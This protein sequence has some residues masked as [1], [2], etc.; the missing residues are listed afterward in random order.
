MKK[1]REAVASRNV[2]ALRSP[3]MP[4]SNNILGVIFGVSRDK[5]KEDGNYRDYG[6]YVGVIGESPCW[7]GRH[8]Q[9][10]SMRLEP[11]RPCRS[12]SSTRRGG[13]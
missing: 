7:Q 13:G 5:G 11:G 9:G 2:D 12:A 8:K 6:D 10:R 4:C 1:L 3:C